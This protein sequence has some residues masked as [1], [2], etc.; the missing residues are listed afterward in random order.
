MDRLVFRQVPVDSAERGENGKG[1]LVAKS[2]RTFRI[3]GLMMF[4]WLVGYWSFTSRHHVRSYQDRWRLAT[5][6]SGLRVGWRYE[7]SASLGN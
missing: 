4:G 1:G 2:P 3:K 7:V 5:V 6:R